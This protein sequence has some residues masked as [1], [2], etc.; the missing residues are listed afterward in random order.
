[1]S[2]GYRTQLSF[3]RSCVR[4][5]LEP[6]LLDG[7]EPLYSPYWLLQMISQ[8]IKIKILF[9]NI[10]KNIFRSI[11]EI[12]SSGEVSNIA[13]GKLSY[14]W[15]GSGKGSSINDVTSLIQDYRVSMIL[16]WQYWNLNTKRRD[17]WRMGVKID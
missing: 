17:N 10:Y 15:S 7:L 1:M 8:S 3:E 9:L 11:Y 12:N 4:I 2:I 13:N 14:E 5:Q 16:W 6:L